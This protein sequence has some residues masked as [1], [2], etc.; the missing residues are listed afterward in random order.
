MYLWKHIP[1]KGAQQ[2]L[3][4]R[5]CMCTTFVASS[6][7]VRSSP[8]ILYIL[9][10]TNAA[11]NK[12]TVFVPIFEDCKCHLLKEIC[13]VNGQNVWC[14]LH[15]PIKQWYHYCNLPKISK[16]C[17]PPFLNKVVAK[18]ALLSLSLST[19]KQ[20]CARGGTNQ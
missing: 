18:G 19:K 8:R 7:A 4:F 12:G 17:P 3:C 13:L 15:V 11:K 16:I 1:W 20:L 2:P 14:S 9:Q 5:L 6:L 10:V